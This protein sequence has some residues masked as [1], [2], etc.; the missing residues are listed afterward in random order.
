MLNE[1][2]IGKLQLLAE[3]ELMINA[4]WHV[5]IEQAKD[6]YDIDVKKNNNELGE[7]LRARIEALEMIKEGFMR[8]RSFKRVEQITK[9]KINKAR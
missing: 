5:L 6:F 4:I 7:E 1:I 2:Q 3:D 9:D 8:L